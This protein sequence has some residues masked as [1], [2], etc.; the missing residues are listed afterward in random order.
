MKT[1]VAYFSAEGK[2]EQFARALAEAAHAELFAIVPEL[3]YTTAD[4]KWTNPL[5]RCNREK[6]GKKTC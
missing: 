5:A 4:L 1:I 2:T 3:P 6:I